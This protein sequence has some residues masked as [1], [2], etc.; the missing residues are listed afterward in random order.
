MA[1]Q[2]SFSL[3]LSLSLLGACVKST[4]DGDCVETDTAT[5]CD[6]SDAAEGSL[7]PDEDGLTN[8]EEAALGTDP[9]NA[10]S[11]GD[12][13]LDGAEIDDGTNPSYTYSH[14]YAGGYNVGFCES[15]YEGTA[16]GA[17]GTGSYDGSSWTA[18]QNG[19]VLENFTLLDQHGEMVDMYSFCGKHV[20][21]AVGA[22]WCGP[23][24]GVAEGLQAEQDHWRD[25]NVQ[26][27][28]I[29]SQDDYGNAPDQAFLKQ[30]HDDYGF[31]DIP[32]LALLEP[33]TTDA[34]A[35]YAHLS[36]LFDQDAY[37]PSI[38]QIDPTGTVVSAD[39]GNSDPS[40]FVE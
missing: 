7:D 16:T 21:F 14:V 1:P 12:G 38:W 24:R 10:D 31:T 25:S 3:I 4:G 28:E 2:T 40:S 33:D 19:D 22:G 36:M 8:D 27:I 20:V 29:I 26:Y 30:W 17:T 9:E 15:P 34:E 39:Q 11:D 18:Y 35:F 37:I 32:V 5:K 6:E 13:V 23:C